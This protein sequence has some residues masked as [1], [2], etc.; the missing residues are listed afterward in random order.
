MDEVIGDKGLFEKVTKSGED[1]GLYDTLPPKVLPF[2]KPGE[3]IRGN[4]VLDLLEPVDATSLY[5]RALGREF[6]C[7]DDPVDVKEEA[8]LDETI[9][10]WQREKSKPKNASDKTALVLISEHALPSS[11]K[12]PQGRHVL[13]FQFKLPPDARSSCPSLVDSPAHVFH[14]YVLTAR[15]DKEKALSWGNVMSARGVWIEQEV[16]IARQPENLTPLVAEMKKQT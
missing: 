13:P 4:L 8:C 7:V 14:M 6:V 3:T 1:Q 10:F 9:I 16:D 5:L 11:G 15:M 2:Y 12:I